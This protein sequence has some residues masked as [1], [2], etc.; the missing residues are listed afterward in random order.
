MVVGATAMATAAE[1]EAAA[2]V[3]GRREQAEATVLGR[4]EGGC[5][6][7]IIHCGGICQLC[8]GCGGGLG[9][10]DALA[11]AECCRCCCDGGGGGG[12]GGSGA[13]CDIDTGG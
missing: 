3:D 7:G 12:G 9:R 6:G 8:G 10:G 13:G 2:P 11:D 1:A 5:H 4:S